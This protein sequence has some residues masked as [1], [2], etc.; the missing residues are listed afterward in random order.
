MRNEPRRPVQRRRRQFPSNRVDIS[1]FRYEIFHYFLA[2]VYRCPVQ[3]RHSLRIR[4]IDVC[5]CFHQLGDSLQGSIL[6]EKEIYIQNLQ[7][8][9]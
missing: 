9:K 7:K 3:Q 2:I 6:Q 4:F 5:S 1:A 8:A